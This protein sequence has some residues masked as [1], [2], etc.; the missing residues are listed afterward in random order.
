MRRWTLIQVGRSVT[1]AGS[2]CHQR[3]LAKGERDHEGQRDFTVAH[4][5]DVFGP[6]GLQGGLASIGS[7]SRNLRSRVR[8]EGH[9]QFEEAECLEAFK[10]ALGQLPPA[11]GV[12]GTQSVAA[13]KPASLLQGSVAASIESYASGQ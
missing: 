13:P 3:T 2:I 5:I 7:D 8:G 6:R 12:G 11:T 1:G 9:L 10:S 4:S